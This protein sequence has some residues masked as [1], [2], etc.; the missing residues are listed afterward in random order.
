MTKRNI[1]KS[2]IA[3]GILLAVLLM[4]LAVSGIYFLQQN[5]FSQQEW[6]NL[7]LTGTYHEG[8][9]IDGI[10]VGGKTL[11]QARDAVKDNMRT[12]QNAIRVTLQYGGQTFE[13]TR[14]DFDVADNVDEV[15]EEA[16]RTA[17]EGN[18]IELQRQL[19]DIA[20]NGMDFSTDYTVGTETV[21]TRLG[22]IASE[23]YEPAQDATIQ[24]DKD[25]RDNRFTYTDE[26]SG[27]AVDEDALYAAVEEQIRLR[28]YGTVQIPVN[29]VPAAVTKASLQ[30]GTAQHITATTSFAKSPYNRE[31]RVEN[32]K[33]AVGIINGYVLAPGEEFSTNTVLGPRTYDLG[34]YP[35]PAIVRGGSEDQAGGG[36]CQVSTTMYNAVLKADLE[37]VDR[38]GHS[39]Q[40]SYVGGGLDATINTGT[41]DFVYKNDT[42]ANV[43]IFCWVDSSQ[44]KVNFEIYRMAFSGDYDE[45]RLSSEKVETLHPDG[46]M[47]VTV[48]TTKAPGYKEE[49]VGRRNG[50]VYK[51][52]KHFYK[53]GEEVG[54]SELIAKTTYKAYTGEIIVGP[55]P[56]PTT[57]PTAPP[58]TE[59]VTNPPPEDTGEEVVETE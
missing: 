4:G 38:R 27:V 19:E 56:A 1:R 47:L 21:K 5:T 53:N 48:D 25:D 26:V 6:D 36:V 18:R 33:K 34:W 11:A 50:S 31:S 3:L 43:Y 14:E 30:A 22:Q 39:I 41:I 24:V 8:I 51:T 10:N 35:A 44:K 49:V 17:R 54:R 55:E 7:L 15:L 20:A 59:P 13:L 58:T 23:L 2:M 29:E 45:I 37:I 40:L 46:E 52:Y 16:M 32:I 9:S 28:E 42:S 12:R 57:A